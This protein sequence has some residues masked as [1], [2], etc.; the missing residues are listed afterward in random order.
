ME[1]LLYLSPTASLLSRT[2]RLHLERGFAKFVLAF[3][4]VDDHAVAGVGD[5]KAVTGNLCSVCQ[6][7][8]LVGFAEVWFVRLS[9]GS[10]T[11]G[12]TA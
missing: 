2:S 1:S 8:V 5:L 12:R 10:R 6:N 7:K 3:L 4:P 9:S 11:C